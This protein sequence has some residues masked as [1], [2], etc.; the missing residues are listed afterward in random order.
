MRERSDG[1]RALQD[2]LGLVGKEKEIELIRI[3]RGILQSYQRVV[4]CKAAAKEK[5][6]EINE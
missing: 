3:C 5:E 6:Q 4:A 2:V 1:K